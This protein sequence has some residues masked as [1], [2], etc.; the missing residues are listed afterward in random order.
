MLIYFYYFQ[1]YRCQNI[2]YKCPW[3]LNKYYVAK[4]DDKVSALYFRESSFNYQVSSIF[5][6]FSSRFLLLSEVSI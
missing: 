3:I 2:I 1:E 5:I 4:I 6:N